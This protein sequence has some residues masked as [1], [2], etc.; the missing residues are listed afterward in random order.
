M[1]DPDTHM[2]AKLLP[3]IVLAAD[4]GQVTGDLRPA[5]RQDQNEV[6]AAG[7][8]PEMP[9]ATYSD[10]GEGAV[11]MLLRY[12][13][14]PLI[15]KA[16]DG[17]MASAANLCA[18]I[19]W[20]IERCPA[21]SYALIVGGHGSGIESAKQTYRRFVPDYERT[22]LVANYV[23]G[24]A[25][26]VPGIKAT[27]DLAFDDGSRQSMSIA[28][29]GMVCQHIAERGPLATVVLD[30]FFMGSIEVAEALMG[31]AMT[32]VA[33][34]EPVPGEGFDYTRL[35][36][37][38]Q[39]LTRLTGVYADDVARAAVEVF[40]DV[41]T[42]FY[43]Y[44]PV[45]LRTRI[46]ALDLFRMQPLLDAMDRTA[47]AVMAELRRDALPTLTAGQR[48]EDRRMAYLG[49]WLIELP[50]SEVDVYS[51]EAVDL[52]DDM[53]IAEWSAD[54]E[55]HG[56]TAYLPEGSVEAWYN[57]TPIGKRPWGQMVKW[58]TEG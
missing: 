10:F 27:V 2:G 37:E 5:M 51:S 23:T 49:Y 15:Q 41:Y 14:P 39:A 9:I 29:L 19:D 55:Q 32:L 50:Y 25:D 26:V 6:F 18:F 54:G 48:S 38:W 45:H 42:S 47:E 1:T 46:L 7:P 12:G 24:G 36:R 52:L 43:A 35:L 13:Q 57:E 56:L 22:A 40:E 58:A 34:P 28:D 4:T 30:A 20:A 33:S 17:N 53:V 16:P 21:E 44:R 8:T 31:S 3:L 11:W